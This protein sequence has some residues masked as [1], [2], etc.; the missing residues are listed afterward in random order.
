MKAS[1]RGEEGKVGVVLQSAMEK[2]DLEVVGEKSRLA[3][4]TK[5]VA[6]QSIRGRAGG[7]RGVGMRLA[8]KAS[9]I[10]AV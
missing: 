2:L 6:S 9:S 5:P 1:C 4:R 7:G 8:L 3:L 10:L